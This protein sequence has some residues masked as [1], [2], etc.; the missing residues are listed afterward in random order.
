MLSNRPV[1]LLDAAKDLL[2]CPLRAWLRT[3]RT[4]L[5]ALRPRLKRVGNRAG[6]PRAV[7]YV[8]ARLPRPLRVPAVRRGL[9]VA[10]VAPL[11]L[12]LALGPT[13]QHP[14]FAEGAYTATSLDADGN[15]HLASDTVNDTFFY[16]T[17]TDS[18]AATQQQLGVDP[19]WRN[20]ITRKSYGLK[21]DGE[22]DY[23]D[24]GTFSY[25]QTAS[26]SIWLNLS[27]L[28]GKSGVIG[29]DN[30]SNTNTIGNICGGIFANSGKVSASVYSGNAYQQI[31]S[32]TVTAGQWHHAVFVRDM[33]SQ[34]ISLYLDGALVNEIAFTAASLGVT[35]GSQR[36]NS[37]LFKIGWY[38]STT[39]A[40]ALNGYFNGVLDEARAYTRTLSADEIQRLYGRQ[41]VSDSNLV[42]RWMLDEGSGTVAKDS[43]PYG[44]DG[45]LMN[46][47]A[48]SPA[49]DGTT[50]G[51]I[52]VTGSNAVMDGFKGCGPEDTTCSNPSGQSG[53]GNLSL[54]SQ[55]STTNDKG[56]EVQMVPSK[57][58]T[59]DGTNDYVSLEGASGFPASWFTIETWFKTDFNGMG[60]LYRYRSY[61]NYF[62]I[63]AGQLSGGFYNQGQTL[64]SV[65]S[66]LSYNDNTWHHAALVYDGAT[67][68]LL[69]DGTD[70]DGTEATGSILYGAGYAAIGRDGNNS[71]VHFRGTLDEVRISD[72]ARYSSNFTPARRLSSDLFTVGLWHL[73]EG[74]GTQAM[75]ASGNGNHGTLMN[76]STN[77][78]AADGTG[79][80]PLWSSGVYAAGT[81]DPLYHQWRQTGG[82]WSAPAPTPEGLVE[83][84]NEEVFLRFH[85]YGMYAPYDTFRIASWAVEAFSTA[86]PQRGKRRSFPEK[87]NLVA[88]QGGVDIIDAQNNLLWMRVPVGAGHLAG[89]AVPLSVTAADGQ[90]LVAKAN[91]SLIIV[92]LSSDSGT[93]ISS[94][95]SAPYAGNIALRAAASWY[96]AQAGNTLLVTGALRD[97]SVAV[98]GGELR[99]AVSGD[100]GVSVVHDLTQF[101]GLPANPPIV[102][103]SRT[104]GNGYGPVALTSAGTLYAANTTQGGLDRWDNVFAD[105]ADRIG[106]A[107]RTYSIASTPALR[108]NAINDILVTEGTSLVEAGKNSV[109]LATDLGTE[110]IEEHSTQANSR[111]RHYVRA[112]QRS[113]GTAWDARQYGGALE[114]SA[115]G[116]YVNF[117]AVT[118]VDTAAGALNT[119]SFWMYWD[120]T[121]GNSRM[122]FAW[123]N[124][125]YDLDFYDSTCFGFNTFNSDCRGISPAGLA[126]QWVHVVAVFNN[127]TP[128]SNQLYINGVE[129]AL[130]QLRGTSV[131]RSAAAM[132]V[133]GGYGGSYTFLGRLDDLRI[134]NRSLSATEVAQLYA[135]PLSAAPTSGLVS[136]WPLNERSGQS[137]FDA[138]G[139]GNDG[140]LGTSI[141]TAV[142]DP[143]R[144]IPS[145]SGP[146]NKVTAVGMGKSG[147][148]G[149]GLQFDGSD[150]YVDLGTNPLAGR[151]A[152]TVS[153]WASLAAV[154]ANVRGLFASTAGGSYFRYSGNGNLLLYI[155][156][157]A[158]GSG[159]S[160]SAG[161]AITDTAFHQYAFSIDTEGKVRIYKDGQQVNSGVFAGWDSACANATEWRGLGTY[162]TEYRWNGKIT[163]TRIYSR[164]L[165]G[166]EVAVLYN[167]GAGTTENTLSNLAAWWK[168]GDASGTLAKDTSGSGNDGLLKNG[169]TNIPAADGTTNGPI[170]STGSPVKEQPALWVAT[171][172]AGSNDG[173]LTAISLATD[174]P[175]TSFTAAT[176]GFPDLDI[177]S[178]SI[179]SGGA[180]AL[181]GTEAGAWNPGTAG[182]PVDDTAVSPATLHQP[183]RLKGGTR[184]KGN[185]RLK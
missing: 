138:S 117:N 173:A 90:L 43:S 156:G 55:S 170:W 166:S 33:E 24:M 145:V 34:R 18:D 87:A 64:F 91:V 127:G 69:I 80:G 121:S 150:D 63:N 2:L 81:G 157:S 108:S 159:Y 125:Q 62:Q 86:S 183:V 53:A 71:G 185:V 28:T 174:Q 10:A 141:S 17:A 151:S 42:G 153:I 21:L 137:V 99:A 14:H 118:G 41:P 130:S 36:C 68:R 67:L 163:D 154:D 114:Y 98:A 149:K 30:N 52:W 35:G 105:T 39:G 129:Q 6:L 126:N 9:L 144:V 16:D 82:T 169:I 38:N 162:A 107:D 110:V 133:L 152:F 32:A 25:S 88:N 57:G 124:A 48:N 13:L 140:T 94:S 135:G 7:S 167:G 54:G 165:T 112:G 51:P 143:I 20:G 83:L 56:Y 103:Y 96:L 113:D 131:S 155:N 45:T 70:V 116:Q 58:L 102:K 175:I 104:A 12:I 31:D 72:T 47:S 44:N 181:V 139:N 40:Q 122:P 37:N 46:G 115:S 147:D 29:N 27:T 15:T 89:Q 22:N 60:N 8:D 4:V 19:N 164:A 120:G 111:V 184:L 77:T 142:D 84:G 123:K 95:G 178:L 171:N 74:V 176:G 93:V 160:L 161:T 172:G 78:P 65:Q 75:D 177:T 73:D 97:V 179:T 146:S 85:P 168:L 5:A 134:Y 119:V 79:S 158:C 180:L 182:F 23:L 132:A 49:A 128:S 50:N 11:L 92:S 109:A 101:A 66:P 76:G 3:H 106:S 136:Y 148:P 26:F 61:G 59:F 100:A 1:R